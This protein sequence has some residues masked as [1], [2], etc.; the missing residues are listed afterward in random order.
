M[1]MK[2]LASIA[3]ASLALLVALDGS[4]PP[5]EAQWRGVNERKW[6]ER[7]NSEISNQASAETICTYSTNFAITSKEE[8]FKD[9]A[10][11]IA[12][13]YCVQGGN[14]TEAATPSAN[15]EEQCSLDSSDIYK[16]SIGKKVY[17]HDS[18]CWSSFH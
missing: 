9:W 17:K 10:N 5:A 4:S 12:Q 14:D 1:P 7:I 8:A 2:H 11:A 6:A 15:E 16:I 13:K 3:A 18:G